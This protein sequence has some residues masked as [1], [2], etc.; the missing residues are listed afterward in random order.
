MEKII[1]EMYHISSDIT[2]TSDDEKYPIEKWYS[3]LLNKTYDQLNIFDVT[4]MLIQKIFLELA[5]PRAIAFIERD[6]F[7]GQRY[8]GEL[9][10]VLSWL[11]IVFIKDYKDVL[12]KILM[13]ASEKNK[14]YDWF[15]EDE[16][17]E[18]DQTIKEFLHRIL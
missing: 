7:C 8:E 10:E 18:F 9:L 4:R 11:D 5:V 13:E 2:N 3:D 12:I 15:F 14:H 17:E 16:R 1:K 6:P